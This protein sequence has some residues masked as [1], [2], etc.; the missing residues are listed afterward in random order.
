MK[1]SSPCFAMCTEKTLSTDSYAFKSRNSS[2][3]TDEAYLA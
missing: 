1:H 3:K 2:I